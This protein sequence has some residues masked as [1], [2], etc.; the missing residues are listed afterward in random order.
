MDHNTKKKY[1]C[2]VCKGK[3]YLI[4]NA[5]KVFTGIFTLGML[6]MLDYICSGTNK[7]DSIYTEKC[8]ECD[9]K[10]FVERDWE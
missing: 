10:K 2:D 5:D 4:N 1:R 6:P 9:G 8:Y 3:G 7:K